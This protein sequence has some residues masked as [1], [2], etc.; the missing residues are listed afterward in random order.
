MDTD[1]E[2]E[3]RVTREAEIRVM[4]L[5]AKEGEH[6]QQPPGAGRGKEGRSPEP[7]GAAWPCQHPDLGSVAF[8][9]G[10]NEL[11]LS[12]PPGMV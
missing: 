7:S 12:Q 10:E 4:C 8:R 9:L 6:R 2:G 11:L 5:Q 3:H 1:A